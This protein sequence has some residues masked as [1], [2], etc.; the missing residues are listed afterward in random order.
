MFNIIYKNNEGMNFV[1]RCSD[2]N[3]RDHFV[4][5][6]TNAGIEYDA[7]ETPEEMYYQICGCLFKSDGQIYTYV[8]PEG[9]A[10]PGMSAA[11]TVMDSYGHETTKEVIIV[12]TKKA[13]VSEIRAIAQKLGRDKLGRIEHVWQRKIA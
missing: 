1:Y 8:R 2:E 13:S 4:S 3:Q 10:K 7:K 5:I 9:D 11:V 6:L 12:D